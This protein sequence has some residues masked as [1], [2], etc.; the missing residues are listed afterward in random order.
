[1]AVPVLLIARS[2]EAARVL[3]SVD[4]QTPALKLRPAPVHEAPLLVTPLGGE[5]QLY[6]GSVGY[7]KEG[8]K[9]PNLAEI[10]TIPAID[11]LGMVEKLLKNAKDEAGKTSDAEKASDAALRR[12][13]ARMDRGPKL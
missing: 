7:G 6:M 2:D 10:K 1:M 4:E 3:V 12:E 11:P 9:W 5:M 8:V 13:I